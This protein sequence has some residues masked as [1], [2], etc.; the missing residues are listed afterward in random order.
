MSAAQVP[1]HAVLRVL[2]TRLRDRRTEAAE[3]REL[4]GA[5]TVLLLHD[6]LSDLPERSEPV[7]TP[8]ASTT[9]S[10]FGAPLA[11]VPIL[12]AGLGMAEAAQR[13]VPGAAVWHLGMARD[14]ATL[15]P[16][17]YYRHVPETIPDSTT[18]LILD[19]MLATGGTAI[20]AASL[21]KAAGIRD[22]RY[23]G[24]LGA[25]EGVRAL[26]EAHPDL[27]IHLAA[28]DERLTG[29]GDPWPHGYILPGLGDAGD[30]L[31]GTT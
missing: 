28:V 8:L 30:R 25:P 19:P 27:A 26:A 23:V 31:F 5:L 1:D 21:L 3:F 16:K 14:H 12:R 6:A 22:L 7:D 10:S 18:A 15:Q 9:G 17:L 11:F 29:P 4:V 24:I 2:L 20:Q 13:M